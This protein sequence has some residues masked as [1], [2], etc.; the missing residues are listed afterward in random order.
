[1]AYT[2]EVAGMGGESE[3]FA[4][5]LGLRV[6]R[7]LEGRVEPGD[8]NGRKEETAADGQGAKVDVGRETTQ[9][10]VSSEKLAK[11]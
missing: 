3:D 5:N 11:F 8:E 10:I 2:N 9:P 4:A 1:M 7:D 6:E